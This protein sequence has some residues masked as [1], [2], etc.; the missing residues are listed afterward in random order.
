M[1]HTR[2]IIVVAL[3]AIVAAAATVAGVVAASSSGSRVGAT[4]TQGTTTTQGATA[5]PG[6]TATPRATGTTSTDGVA[7]GVVGTLTLVNPGGP[8]I[9]AGGSPAPAPAIVVELL[10]PTTNA[11]IARARVGAGGSFRVSVPPGSYRV[12]IVPAAGGPSATVSHL[13]HVTDNGYARLVLGPVR[14]L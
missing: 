6:T 10:S 12:L 9:A 8:M 13:V 1:K 4:A 7:T 2:V 3:I 11:V 5:T 14:G